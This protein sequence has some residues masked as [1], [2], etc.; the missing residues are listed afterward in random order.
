MF[1]LHVGR[2]Q[3]ELAGWWRGPA[4]VLEN[5]EWWEPGP[6]AEKQIKR[7]MDRQ[8]EV[9]WDIEMM[10][11]RGEKSRRLPTRKEKKKKQAIIRTCL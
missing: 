5:A 2:F 4:G 7:K 11:D 9:L 6:A 10:E 1:S 8:E 3:E